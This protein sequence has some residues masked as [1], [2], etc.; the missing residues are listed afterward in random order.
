MSDTTA[1]TVP[2][3]PLLQRLADGACLWVDIK[4]AE[5]QSLLRA[6]NA[7]IAATLGH[8]DD[9]VTLAITEEG[10][11]AAEKQ[12]LF[13]RDLDNAEKTRDAQAGS[14]AITDFEVEPLRGMTLWAAAKPVEGVV[15]IG[16]GQ[17]DCSSITPADARR[18]ADALQTIA[19]ASNPPADAPHRSTP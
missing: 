4:D 2:A 7:Y 18:F 13:F 10:R 6:G 16:H 1:A 19:A 3:P 8:R 15:M 14:E 5:A 11:T 9:V 12:R 17:G